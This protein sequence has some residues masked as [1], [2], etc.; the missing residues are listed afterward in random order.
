MRIAWLALVVLPLAATPAPAAAASKDMKAVTLQ[1]MYRN[2]TEKMKLGAAAFIDGFV[3]GH[4]R[5]KGCPAKDYEAVVARFLAQPP[6]R[7]GEVL[8]DEVLARLTDEV[9]PCRGI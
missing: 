7:L 9:H 8:A 2:G 4:T 5:A 3:R 1:Q 6:G